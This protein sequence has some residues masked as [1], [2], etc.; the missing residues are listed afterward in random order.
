MDATCLEFCLA[1]YIAA[2]YIAGYL[3]MRP[4]CCG[5]FT[6]FLI[7][8]NC[9]ACL[10]STMLCSQCCVLRIFAVQLTAAMLCIGVVLLLCFHQHSSL[11]LGP[12]SISCRT[13]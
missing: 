4:A 9:T 5:S 13:E 11:A 1:S 10:Q 2:T 6:Y 8:F 7:A 12:I 3:R